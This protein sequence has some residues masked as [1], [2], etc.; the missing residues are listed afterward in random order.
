ML[1]FK[2]L[3]HDRKEPGGPANPVQLGPDGVASGGS[4]QGQTQCTNNNK[5]ANS[6]FEG[7]II[8]GT[9]RMN[10]DTRPLHQGMDVYRLQPW[11]HHWYDGLLYDLHIDRGG[12][13]LHLG[14]IS[15]GCIN[16]DKRNPA[17][18]DQYRRLNLGFE[19][20]DARVVDENG[21]THSLSGGPDPA[22]NGETLNFWNTTTNLPPFSGHTIYNR[23]HADC[24]TAKCLI[25]GHDRFPQ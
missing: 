9:Y 23:L 1:C 13:E 22:T 15:L 20:C 6:R 11:P 5:C 4:M 18:A 17:A 10:Y 25:N 12:F 19:H 24:G 14:T 3:W 2:N 21:T 8:P 7:P 16:A